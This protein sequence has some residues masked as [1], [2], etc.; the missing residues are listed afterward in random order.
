EALI[1]ILYRRTDTDAIFFINDDI[2][3]GAIMECSRRDIKVGKE[4]DIVGLNDLELSKVL[5]PSCTT[6]ANPRFEM[7]KMGDEILIQCLTS[8]QLPP[9]Q[10]IELPFKFMRRQSA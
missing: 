3:V 4:L 9:Q 1:E 5:K 8:K 2:A 6:I 7:C 10:I